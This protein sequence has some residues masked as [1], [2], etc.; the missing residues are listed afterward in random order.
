M[1]EKE[2]IDFSEEMKNAYLDYAMSVIRQSYEAA[3]DK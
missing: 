3:P 2:T 1:S